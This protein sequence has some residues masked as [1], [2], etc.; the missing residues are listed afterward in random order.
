MIYKIRCIQC[1]TKKLKLGYRTCSKCLKKRAHFA[2]IRKKKFKKLG[3]CVDC[4]NKVKKHHIRCEK[5]LQIV[6]DSGKKYD[7]KKKKEC[8]IK[9]SKGKCCCKYCGIKDLRVLTIDHINNNGASHRKKIKDKIYEFLIKRKFP[10]GYQV[11]CINCQ[12]IKEHARRNS[13]KVI[14]NNKKY[15]LKR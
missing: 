13:I 3:I 15:I 2:Q 5:C 8:L 12:W 1:G 4:S 14:L 7:L 9:Y 11:L 6:R 10:T